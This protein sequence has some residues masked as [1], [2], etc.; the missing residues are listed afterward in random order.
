[1]SCH[2]IGRGMNNVVRVTMRLMDEGK[3]SKEAAKVI[4]QCCAKSVYWCDGNEYEATDYIRRCI[5]GK[6]MTLVPKGEKLYSI[7]RIKDPFKRVPA[8]ARQFDL[9]TGSLCEACFD[10]IFNKYYGDDTAGERER[11]FIEAHSN[12]SDEYLSTGEYQEDNNGYSWGD[13]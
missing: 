11:Q 8:I 9:A 3:I 6:C 1:M 4:V 13:E 7:W 2:D 5:C 10:S 12:N